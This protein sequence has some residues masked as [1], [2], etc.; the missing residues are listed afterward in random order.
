MIVGID[1]GNSGALVA[2]Y[3]D[4]PIDQ[5][6]MPLVQQ[7]KSWRVNSK[8]V[9]KFLREVSPWKVYIEN[10]HSM[11]K[12]GV[13]STF[14]FGHAAGAVWGICGALNI[15]VVLVDPAMWKRKA[16]LLKSTKDDSRLK[17]QEIWPLWESLNKKAL[18]QAYAEA[19]MIAYFGNKNK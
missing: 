16:G 10:V 9:A 8:A 15:D 3:N 13:A 5:I 19:A 6:K 7:G 11:P 1:P 2:L 4:D 18:G 12:Q 17:A 14:T